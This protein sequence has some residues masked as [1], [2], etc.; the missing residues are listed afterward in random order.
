MS[1]K[2]Y[3][4]LETF[5][6]ILTIFAWVGLVATVISSVIMFNLQMMGS[7]AVAVAILVMGILIT[8]ASLAYAQLLALAIDLESNTQ[9]SIEELKKLTKIMT[10]AFEEKLANKE[11]LLEK[12]KLETL[13]KPK[14]ERVKNATCP[15]CESQV[16]NMD[17]ECWKCKASFGELSTW[18]PQP[19]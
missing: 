3:E 6:T 9:D 5:I 12:E 2:K 13:A 10:I 1:V 19:L 17:E 4:A 11:N 16:N 7:G 15:N 8:I 18:R 14:V